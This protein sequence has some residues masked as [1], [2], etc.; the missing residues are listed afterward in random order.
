MPEGNDADPSVRE[1]ND[2][3]KITVA[4]A[5]RC[6]LNG[7]VFTIEHPAASLIWQLT[8]ARRLCTWTNARTAPPTR[9]PHACS[10]T[11][12]G[13]K[14]R[15]APGRGRTRTSRC[16]AGIW[17]YKDQ[18]NVWHTAEAAEYPWGLA[19]AL[20]EAFRD[21]RPAPAPNAD[22][23][24][25]VLAVAKE[26]TGKDIREAENRECLGGLRNLRE[27]LA[28]LPGWVE[29]GAQIRD[30]ADNVARRMPALLHVLQR[31]ATDPTAASE[32]EGP[33]LEAGADVAGELAEKWQL[34]P[35]ARSST[36]TCSCARSSSARPTRIRT[37][38]TGA[39]DAL[40]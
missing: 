16:K 33:L 38:R 7:G 39:A 18:A 15:R 25:P 36:A 19:C 20:A 5:E 24:R 31:L 26:A 14:A 21:W 10:R 23:F 22:P 3:A 35:E 27:S 6:A 11:P 37:S 17:S 1:A 13:S 12:S 8:L 4:L 30:V 32:L 40:R 9:N 28:R 34:Q 29:V 2:L